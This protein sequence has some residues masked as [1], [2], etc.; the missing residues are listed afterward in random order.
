MKWSTEDTYDKSYVGE[1]W[2][3]GVTRI[4]IIIII[5]FGRARS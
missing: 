3:H 1:V 2:R 5:M 4:I